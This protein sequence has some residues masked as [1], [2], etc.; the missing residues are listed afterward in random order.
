MEICPEMKEFMQLGIPLPKYHCNAHKR[1]I[2]GPSYTDF[3]I[4]DII[5]KDDSNYEI[6]TTFLGSGA[7][8]DVYK[9]KKLDT[10]E[11]VAMKQ[12]RTKYMKRFE[13]ECKITNVVKDGPFI[14]KSHDFLYDKEKKETSIVLEYLG[15]CV[16][17]EE[18]WPTLTRRDI[19]RYI[20]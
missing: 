15:N 11:D 12:I 17:Y 13:Y 9:G 5:A 10:G 20:L 14:V 1:S 16:D 2:Y 18:M 8:A 3:N 4:D 7:T 19:K 6:T